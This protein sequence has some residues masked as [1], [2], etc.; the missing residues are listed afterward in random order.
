MLDASECSELKENGLCI[1]SVG[2]GS[3]LTVDKSWRMIQCFFW[4]AAGAEG[5]LEIVDSS[6]VL[7][8]F[9][10]DSQ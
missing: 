6:G 3:R 2:S 4:L 8:S 7:E 10:S 5:R 1:V 9:Q